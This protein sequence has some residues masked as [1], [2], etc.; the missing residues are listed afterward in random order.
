MSTTNPSE[1]LR[2]KHRAPAPAWPGAPAEAGGVA[3]PAGSR[4]WPDWANTVIGLVV[5]G[6]LHGALF[7]PILNRTPEEAPAPPTPA[8][9]YV[10]LEMPPIEPPEPIEIVDV[11]DTPPDTISAPPMAMDLPSTVPVSAFLQPI[12]P[13]LDPSLIK[14]GAITI[15]SFNATAGTPGTGVRLFELKELDRVPRR[16]RTVMP[17]YPHEL[18]KAGVSG[19]VVLLVIIDASGRVE[20][21]RVVSS[22]HREFEAAAVK[23]A[24]QCVFVSPLRAGQRVSARYTWHIPFELK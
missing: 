24:Q 1:S 19:E 20:V 12:Q 22:T 3:T 16:L 13:M 14:V 11:S 7:L 5:S 4:E 23:A 17:V 9:T 10:Q 2:L 21:E 18:R 6:A 15:P 8:A